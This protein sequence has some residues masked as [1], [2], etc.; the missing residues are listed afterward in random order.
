MREVL[1]LA[2]FRRLFAGSA[3]SAV[4]DQVLPVAVPVLVLDRGGSAGDPGL[5]LAARFAA[6]ALFGLLGGVWAEQ[7]PGARCGTQTCSSRSSASAGSGRSPARAVS[8]PWRPG[9][10]RPDGTRDARGDS[11]ER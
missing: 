10:A 6:I 11:A 8:W 2:F 9:P 4:A 7:L 5:L 1:R 3:A